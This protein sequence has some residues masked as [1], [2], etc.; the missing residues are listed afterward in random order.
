MRIRLVKSIGVL[1]FF[2]TLITAF[3]KSLQH[4]T[5]QYKDKPIQTIKATAKHIPSKIER[6]FDESMIWAG[7]ARSRKLQTLL[8]NPV[9]RSLHIPK[10]DEGYRKKKVDVLII[11]SSGPRRSERRKAIRETWMKDCVPTY[12]VSQCLC[13]KFYICS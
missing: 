8:Q 9:Y 1:A 6:L 5:D 2:I 3:Y 13:C 12:G 10:P 7:Q 11:V 4:A